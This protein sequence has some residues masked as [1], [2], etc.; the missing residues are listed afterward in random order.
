MTFEFFFHVID[1]HSMSKLSSPPPGT[2]MR[3]SIAAILAAVSLLNI[4][5]ARNDCRQGRNTRI[6]RTVGAVVF[7]IWI[8]WARVAAGVDYSCLQDLDIIIRIETS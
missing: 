3:R 7:S 1:C 5:L 2:A 6:L 8:Q 4:S